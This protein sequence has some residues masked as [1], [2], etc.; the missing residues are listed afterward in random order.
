MM[1]NVKNISPAS[2][3]TSPSAPFKATYIPMDKRDQGKEKW[4]LEQNT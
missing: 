3:K 2:Y 4:C 1:D